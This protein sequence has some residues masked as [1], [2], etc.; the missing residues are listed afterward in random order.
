MVEVRAAQ[1]ASQ[2]DQ[3]AGHR[4]ANQNDVTTKRPH[5]SRFHLFMDWV[6]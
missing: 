1:G 3:E 2:I 6:S 5:D 4:A